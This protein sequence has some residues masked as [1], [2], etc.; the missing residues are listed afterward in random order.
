MAQHAPVPPEFHR[1]RRLASAILAGL[2][3]VYLGTFVPHST[4]QWILFVRSMAEAG[5]VGGLADW[6]AVT[7]LFR[8]PL[9]LRIPHTALLPRNKTRAA[10]TIAQFIDE[11]FLIWDHVAPQ[12]MAARPLRRLAI[13]LTRTGAARTVATEFATLA[14]TVFTQVPGRADIAATI[15]G[16]L[17][18]A[19]S[20]AIRPND[21]AQAIQVVFQGG[22]RGK[23]VTEILVQ[24]RHVVE[25]NR[26][27]LT[28]L[29]QDNSRWWIAAPVDRQVVRVMM[30]GLLSVLDDL[31][32]ETSPARIEFETKLDQFLRSLQNSDTVAAHV[33]QGLT[34]YF[35]SPEFEKTMGHVLDHILGAGD[36]HQ[37]GVEMLEQVIRQ[38]ASAIVRNPDLEQ[39]L[40]SRM[41]TGVSSILDQMRPWVRGYIERVILSWDD[42]DLVATVEQQVGRDLQFIRINGSILGA[43]IGGILFFVEL[44][45]LG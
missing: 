11:N 18:S 39:R 22:A 15:T 36:D 29:V 30:A 5:M 3:V 45:F 16:Q 21:L 24:V 6:F 40:Q 27:S 4:P 43:V 12:I 10:R 41:M 1:M 31:I 37:R 7:A 2:A 38:A 17:R 28:K 8:H 25:T 32:D 26:D 44:A 19:L 9:G 14:Q 33:H 35:A 20:R 23:I 13:G 42:Q 34:G